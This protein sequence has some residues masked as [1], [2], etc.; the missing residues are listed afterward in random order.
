M[1]PDDYFR[2]STEQN[3]KERSLPDAAIVHTEVLFLKTG[4]F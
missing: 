2:E 4:P 3:A 1:L